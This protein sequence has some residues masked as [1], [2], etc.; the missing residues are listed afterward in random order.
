MTGF[1]SKG[2]SDPD[3]S[4]RH[5]LETLYSLPAPELRESGENELQPKGGSS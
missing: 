1:C 5:T 4:L 2:H 3:P